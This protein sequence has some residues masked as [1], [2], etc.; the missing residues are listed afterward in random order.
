MWFGKMIG[1]VAGFSFGGPLGAVLGAIV[2]HT[3]DRGLKLNVSQGASWRGDGWGRQP[4]EESAVWHQHCEDKELPDG[5]IQAAFFKATFLVMGR[6]AKS[7]GRVSDEEIALAGSLMDQLKL[8]PNM[9]KHAID[10]FSQGKQM[11]FDL[12]SILNQFHTLSGRRTT[13][14][15]MFMEIQCQAAYADGFLHETE[16]KLI[17]QVAELLYYPK[18]NL[19]QIL[20]RY[21]AFYSTQPEGAAT[22]GFS[23][24]VQS[25]A[26]LGVDESV[27]D[28]E[29]KKA[30]RRLMSQ[31]H[32]D[33]LVAKGL[34]EEMMALATEKTQQIRAAYELIRERRS[35][36]P[37]S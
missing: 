9:K 4:L 25:Y 32:P 31:H 18:R 7:D 6:V 21:R 30:Y 17:R 35:N 27:S 36:V 20:Q 33:K 29:L 26:L 1:A 24:L 16:L 23:E 11:D 2:G 19:E 37:S 13:L 12:T 3:F 8:S 15:Q 5:D 28:A 22:T 10:L 34:P 14:I